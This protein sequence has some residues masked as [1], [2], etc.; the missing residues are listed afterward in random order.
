M[1]K[2]ADPASFCGAPSVFTS[3]SPKAFVRITAAASLFRRNRHGNFLSTPHNSYHIYAPNAVL[4]QTTA[5]NRTETVYLPY[6][7][8]TY[9]NAPEKLS[10]AFLNRSVIYVLRDPLLLRV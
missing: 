2:T 6:S 7:F 9:K 3:L 8:R 5:A 10:G 4:L 1:S